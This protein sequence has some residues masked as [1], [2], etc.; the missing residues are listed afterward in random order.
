MRDLQDLPMWLTLCLCALGSVPELDRGEAAVFLAEGNSIRNG[1]DL[2]HYDHVF[3][4]ETTNEQVYS[5]MARDVVRTVTT[6]GSGA[7][8]MYGATGSGK[9]WTMTGGPGDPGIVQRAI[10]D[11]FMELPTEPTTAVNMSVLEV[12]NEE[13]NDLFSLKGARL[14]LRQ[15]TGGIGC[16]VTGLTQVPL[17]SAEDAKSALA[18]GIANRKV[19]STAMNDNSSRS[20]K[21]ITFT[22]ARSAPGDSATSTEPEEALDDVATLHLVDLAGS[23]SGRVTSCRDRRRESASINKSLLA[24]GTVVSAL[25]EGVASHVNFRDS[26]LTRLL[27]ATLTGANTQRVHAAADRQGDAVEQMPVGKSRNQRKFQK[28]GVDGQRVP[29]QREG[30]MQGLMMERVRHVVEGRQKG[31]KGSGGRTRGNIKPEE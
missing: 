5:A 14:E 13:L 27:Q 15:A 9:T 22:V 31:L 28:K 21:L 17:T 2:F 16:Y 23:E 24:L 18:R 25:S 29:H 12:Y 11:L 30:V 20:H 8:L 4:K 19:R 1:A 10:T 6:G 3:N 7:V 26:K